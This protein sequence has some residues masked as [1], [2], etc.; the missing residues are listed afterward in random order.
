MKEN[1]DDRK[2]L[3]AE[4]SLSDED[5]DTRKPQTTFV[6]SVGHSKMAE[7]H[8]GDLIE[9]EPITECSQAIAE[10]LLS[11][12]EPQLEETQSEAY[13][14]YYE[15]VIANE[16]SCVQWANHSNSSTRVANHGSDTLAIRH[17][18]TSSIADSSLETEGVSVA[19]IIDKTRFSEQQ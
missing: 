17:K 10:E 18:R 2:S 8:G 19:R 1:F 13:Q 7:E 3:E 9:P 14:R 11:P 5:G 6:T 12:E 4:V 15:G 16:D